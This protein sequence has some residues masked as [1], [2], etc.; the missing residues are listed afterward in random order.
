[1]SEEKYKISDDEALRLLKIVG[2]NSD[3]AEHHIPQSDFLHYERMS[4]LN[5]LLF[6]EQEED[7]SDE[8]AREDPE[9]EAWNEKRVEEI[10]KRDAKEREQKLI[11]QRNKLLLHTDFYMQPDAD[12]TDEEKK[13]MEDW[14][15][16]LRDAP[17]SS[18]WPKQLP[19]APEVKGVYKILEEVFNL[20]SGIQQEIPYFVMPTEKELEEFK[21]D[22]RYDPDA[23]E[24]AQKLS[25]E[26]VAKFVEENKPDEDE[27][28]VFKPLFN[29][30]I[31][32]EKEID[33]IKCCLNADGVWVLA[34]EI[35][36]IKKYEEEYKAQPQAEPKRARDK[37]GKFISDDPNTPDYNEA[38]EGGKAPEK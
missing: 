8:P 29:T 31:V 6:K 38:W 14:R 3:S 24:K 18:S 30:E 35:E 32:E 15:Q 27:P 9:W 26:K 37:D 28:I 33:G 20:Q 19:A 17:K 34:S 2:S 25:E 22:E 12:I 36:S 7:F 21:K 5:D 10:R 16:A 1:M 11:A 4:N 13:L 23:I